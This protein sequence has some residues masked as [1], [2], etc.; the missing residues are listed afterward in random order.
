MKTVLDEAQKQ[1]IEESIEEKRRIEAEI[2]ARGLEARAALSTPAVR[3]FFALGYARLLAA[4]RGYSFEADP[5]MAGLKE[6]IDCLRVQ[7]S[8]ETYLFGC[9]TAA[10]EVG[11]KALFEGRSAELAALDRGEAP[12]LDGFPPLRSAAGTL[13]DHAIRATPDGEALDDFYEDTEGED[14]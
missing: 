14:A 8:L 9:V 3:E 6:V 2:L 1:R 4:M 13:T 10:Q 5:T 7:S 12:D 11:R